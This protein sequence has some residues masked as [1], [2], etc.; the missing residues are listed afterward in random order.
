MNPNT[1][2][3][4]VFRTQRD[5]SVV[6]GI[7]RR[8]PV[9]V[10]R[11]PAAPQVL[12]PVAYA[13]QLDMTNDSGLFR[14]AE[15]LEA[16]GAYPVV[17]GAW[18]RGNTRYLPLMVGRSIHLFDHRYASVMEDD[19]EEAEVEDDPDA[20][21]VAP[22]RTRRA[23][24]SRNV[25]NPYSSSQTNPAQHADPAFNPR[26]R[27]WVEDAELE[28]RWPAGL[29]WAMAFRDI[30]R[31]TDARTVISCIV[32]RAAFGNTLP[33]LL[34][35]LPDPLPERSRKPD[36]MALW[37]AECDR[38]L[39]D[40]KASTPLLVGNLGALV[41]D[42]VARNKVQSTHL[43]SYILEQ[44]PL[45]PRDGFTRR[46]G[47]LSAEQ[48]VRREVLALSY[49]AHDLTPF[50][51]DQGYNGEPF[52]WDEEDR[53]R[54]RALLDAVFMLLYGLDREAAGYVLNTFLI[55]RRQEEERPGKRYRTRD[56]VLR[57]MAALEAGNPDVKMEG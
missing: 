27:Y 20:A 34:P 28:D 38:V 49:T 39:L 8:L 46:F 15:E 35:A 16:D 40:Y 18:E 6:L 25:H 41:L 26:P 47:P 7:Y 54:R 4:P 50:A 14:S 37:R 2:T 31:P 19:S 21:G 24:R 56:L 10:D 45:V 23:T 32:P 42:Y 33:L 5:A 57:Y 30:A 13:R 48:I 17:G 53:L 52:A 43:N 1:G 3:A 44:L 55:V 29:E 36:S 51:R 12:Y 9:L 11:R 22:T